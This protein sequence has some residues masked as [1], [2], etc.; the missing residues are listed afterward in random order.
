[1]DDLRR[2]GLERKKT[3]LTRE[4]IVKVENLYKMKSNTSIRRADSQLRAVNTKI[5]Y[6]LVKK[7]LKTLKFHSYRI[8]LKFDLKS[9][10]FE[11]PIEFCQ[12]VMS[13][14]NANEKF[15]NNILM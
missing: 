13:K 6:S 9:I 15:L 10:D 5:S 11:P 3:F 1:V 12:W 14:I 8:Q 4:N 7:V 2:T